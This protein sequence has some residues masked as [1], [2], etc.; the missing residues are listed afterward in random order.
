MEPNTELY[1]ALISTI[2][3]L[4]IKDPDLKIGLVKRAFELSKMP[5]SFLEDID[6]LKNNLEEKRI[7]SDFKALEKIKKIR[8]NEFICKVVEAIKDYKNCKVSCQGDLVNSII[9]R[10]GF[11][12]REAYTIINKAVEYGAV[13]V[14]QNGK[15]KTFY[16]TE[17]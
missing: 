4:G 7:E 11:T 6:T 17:C 2:K 16:L 14:I 9:N 12:Y 10:T 13:K 1:K 5:L 8:D 15:R 3:E